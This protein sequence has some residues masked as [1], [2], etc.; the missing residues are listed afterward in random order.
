MM[1]MMSGIR[2][3]RPHERED[4][5]TDLLPNSIVAESLRLRT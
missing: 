4:N 3:L 1:I 5:G 2:F